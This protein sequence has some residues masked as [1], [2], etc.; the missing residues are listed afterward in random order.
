M[1]KIKPEEIFGT[2]AG[3][4]WKVLKEKGELDA[5]SIVRLTLLRPSEVFGALGWLGRE[6]KIEIIETKEK[7]LYK[8][9]E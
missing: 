4:V 2:N 6:G 1:V 8:L 7:R 9:I 5:E 3:K